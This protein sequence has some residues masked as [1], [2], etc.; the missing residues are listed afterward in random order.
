MSQ[1]TNCQHLQAEINRLE[2]EVQKLQKE[3]LRLKRII[4][5]AEALCALVEAEAS[6]ILATNQ[7][8]GVWAYNKGKKESADR[9]SQ[10]LYY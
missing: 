8:K 7:P 3:V 4:D 6:T 1:C 2:I 9:I 5:S 10:A